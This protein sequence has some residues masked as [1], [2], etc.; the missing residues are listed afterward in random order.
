MVFIYILKLK[1]NKYYVGKT[2]DP[3][4]RL[5]AHQNNSGSMWTKKYKPIKVI[6]L[7]EGDKYDEDKYVHKYMDKY[8]IENVRGGSYSSIKLRKDQLNNLKHINKSQNDRCFK[9]NRKGHFASN[10]HYK[11]NKEFLEASNCYESADEVEFYSSEDEENED[12]EITIEQLEELFRETNKDNGVYEYDGKKYL[13]DDNEL[14]EESPHCRCGARDG[15]FNVS[16]AYEYWRPIKKNKVEKA[17]KNTKGK[18]FK[19]GR[20]GHWASKC[21]AKTHVDGYYI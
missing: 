17:K 12:E 7:F 13:W 15:T 16:Y 20:K 6:E 4:L 21:Y 9:C 11:K 18:C 3:D 2:E 14:F 8:G 19:C 5:L 10:C 1:N